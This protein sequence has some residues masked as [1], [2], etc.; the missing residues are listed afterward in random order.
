MVKK[1]GISVI[2]MSKEIDKG[3]IIKEHSSN[4]M[5]KMILKK[6]M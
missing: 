2:K 5:K 6:Y 3:K 1:I 4:L